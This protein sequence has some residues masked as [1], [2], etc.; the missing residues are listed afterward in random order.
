M[1]LEDAGHE[2]HE[3]ERDVPFLRQS[4][5]IADVLGQLGQMAVRGGALID[6]VDLFRPL[7]GEI[8]S[9][10]LGGRDVF[11]LLPTGGGKSLCYQVPALLSEGTAVVVSPPYIVTASALPS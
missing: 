11:V 9:S 7:Q 5:Q 10:L 8:V 4:T 6:R 2:R 1:L 3:L